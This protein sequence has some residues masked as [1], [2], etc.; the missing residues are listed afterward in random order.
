MRFIAQHADKVTVDGLRWGVEP[1]CTVLTEHGTP[2]APSTYYDARRRR[3]CMSELRDEQL[4]VEDERVWKDNYRVYGAR[5]VWLQL[6]R[7]GIPVARCMVERLMRDL[8]LEGLAAAGDTAPPSQSPRRR[9]RLIWC[10][11]SSRPSGRT[12]SGSP[13][14]RMWR[15]GRAPSTSP[16]SWTPNLAGSWAGAPPAR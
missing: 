15:H 11:A 3:P 8:G 9:E 13:T 7:E 5:K 12:G 10:S 14:S 16:S 6:N 2:I 4:R 1:I